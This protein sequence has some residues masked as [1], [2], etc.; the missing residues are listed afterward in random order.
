VGFPLLLKM[1]H[2]LLHYL[3]WHRVFVFGAGELGSGAAQM[4]LLLQRGNGR[5]AVEE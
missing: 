1:S 2:I 3:V 5:Q 4:S